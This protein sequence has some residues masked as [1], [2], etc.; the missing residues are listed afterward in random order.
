V[1]QLKSDSVNNRNCLGKWYAHIVRPQLLYG[2]TGNNI[3][4]LNTTY[5]P[6]QRVPPGEIAWVSSQWW[7][8]RVPARVVGGEC[9]GLLP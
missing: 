9:R 2:A 5:L 4:A 3:P 7:T 8:R 1:P 6:P